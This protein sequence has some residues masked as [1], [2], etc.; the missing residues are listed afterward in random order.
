[1]RPAAASTASSRTATA[2]RP[3]PCGPVDNAEE[4]LPTGPQGQQMQIRPADDIDQEA[5]FASQ[6]HIAH[7]RRDHPKI[8]P[9]KQ[10]DRP[11]TA[12]KREPAYAPK[13]TMARPSDETF[14]HSPLFLGLQTVGA[15]A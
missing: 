6:G 9:T 4:A 12:G 13:G 2:H 3:L 10:S 14:S 7:G 11:R 5:A 8:P 15:V 1:M